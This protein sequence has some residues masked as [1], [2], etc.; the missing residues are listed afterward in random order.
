[1]DEKIPTGKNVHTG[2]IKRNSFTS[3][4][5]PVM[6]NQYQRDL[7]QYDLSKL[8]LSDR[9]YL[10]LALGPL[11]KHVLLASARCLVHTRRPPVSDRII[12]R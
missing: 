1:M 2:F 11:T 12:V 6:S 9:S 7:V 5:T 4:Y 3:E 10:R 8:F